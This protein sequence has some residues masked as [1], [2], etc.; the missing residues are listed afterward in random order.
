[1]NDAGGDAVTDL[2]A[3]EMAERIVRSLK[4]NSADFE[5]QRLEQR[6]ASVRQLVVIFLVFAV[7]VAAGALLKGAL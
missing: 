5:R 6:R 2:T 1:L 3:N 4:Q 7:G